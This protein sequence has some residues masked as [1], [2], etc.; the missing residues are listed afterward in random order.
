MRKGGTVDTSQVTRSLRPR[1]WLVAATSAVILIAGALAAS[2]SFA[3]SQDFALSVAPA[4]ATVAAGSSARYTL[5]ATSENGLAGTINVGITSVSPAV[6]NGPTFRL[7]RYEIW[8]SPT[9][10][11]GGALITASTTSG[12]PATTY[13][14]TVTG[15]DITGGASHGLTHTT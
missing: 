12:T 11:N 1:W 14:V 6:A 13:T 2:R 5:T 7:S 3:S 15:R 10:P 8:V 4:T 9:A